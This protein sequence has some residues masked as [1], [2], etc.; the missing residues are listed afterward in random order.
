MSVLFS[1][2]KV[3]TLFLCAKTFPSYLPS[4]SAKK[5]FAVFNEENHPVNNIL[6]A[7]NHITHKNNV[8]SIYIPNFK[9]NANILKKL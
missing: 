5:R 6:I 9:E 2:F 7:K 8:I 4:G 3:F 1:F